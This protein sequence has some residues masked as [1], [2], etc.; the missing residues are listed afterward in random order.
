MA[1][2]QLKGVASHQ[3]F[4]LL[5][6]PSQTRHMM[7]IRLNICSLL[8]VNDVAFV[9]NEKCLVNGHIF[10]LIIPYPL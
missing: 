5:L 4:F 8:Y 2:T 1:L 7:V 10:I 9:K 3:L 6:S